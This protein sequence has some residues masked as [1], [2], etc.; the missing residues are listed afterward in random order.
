M[1]VCTSRRTVFR[2][3]KNDIFII[4]HSIVNKINRLFHS[5]IYIYSIVLN[6]CV[7]IDIT[8][9]ITPAPDDDI[10][11]VTLLL[12]SWQNGEDLLIGF[13]LDPSQH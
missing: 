9:V 4:I 13:H 6:Y 7:L 8:I 12:P 1:T 2:L 10:K 5:K 3:L 11:K